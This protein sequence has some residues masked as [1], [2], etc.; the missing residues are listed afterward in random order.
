VFV[1]DWFYGHHHHFPNRLA[2]RPHR[3]W[4]VQFESFGGDALVFVTR[5]AWTLPFT[6]RL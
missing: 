1:V 4:R 5:G 3:P 2:Y 6:F